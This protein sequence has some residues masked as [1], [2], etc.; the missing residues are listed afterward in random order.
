MWRTDGEGKLE[1]GFFFHSTQE[2]KKG[3]LLF[4]F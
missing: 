4:S 2:F 3:K 1:G